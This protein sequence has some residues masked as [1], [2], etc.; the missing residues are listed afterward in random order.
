MQ[1]FTRSVNYCKWSQCCERLLGSLCMYRWHHS[2]TGNRKQRP[3]KKTNSQNRTV[4]PGRCFRP[5]NGDFLCCMTTYKKNGCN[6]APF[7]P[8]FDNLFFWI[9]LLLQTAW[10][11]NKKQEG[12]QGNLILSI[13]D[14]KHLFSWPTCIPR[15]YPDWSP[16]MSCFLGARIRPRL[17][18]PFCVYCAI[19]L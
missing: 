16:E 5:A 7:L 2:M 12:K 6:F 10:N 14:Y 3:R 9:N 1:V 15:R 8:A 13:L 17:N 19:G 4:F 11:K 18:T